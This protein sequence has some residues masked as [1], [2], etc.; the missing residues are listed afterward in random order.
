M[1]VMP[2]REVIGVGS[3][4]ES[5]VKMCDTLR[6]LSVLMSIAAVRFPVRKSAYIYTGVCIHLVVST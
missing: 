2:G 5:T 4:L 6:L 3:G 1:K